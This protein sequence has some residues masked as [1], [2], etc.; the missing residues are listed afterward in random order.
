[1]N[2]PAKRVMPKG[3]R[4]G[5]ATFPRMALKD[6][7]DYAKKLVSKSH[8]APITRDV[9]YSGVLG[10]K[11]GKGN[12]KASAVKQYGLMV[13][14]QKS[15]FSASELAKKIYTALPEELPL[16]LH[17]AALSPSIFKAIFDTFH[18][19]AVPRGKLRQ[20]AADLNV[21]P[22]QAE[23]CADIYL[24][25]MVFAG[26]VTMDGDRTV[27]VASSSL[28]IKSSA[29]EQSEEVDDEHAEGVEGSGAESLGDDAVD[30]E[31]EDVPDTEDE[32][33][34]KVA[35]R[36]PVLPKAVININVSLDSTTDSDKLA[37]QLALL[38]KYGAL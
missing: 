28:A 13:G 18:S 7:V 10:A 3:G 38:R 30:D 1:M 35:P 21:H 8:T 26:L 34:G 12:V 32:R 37:K 22:D 9:L 31:G 23:D 5:G 29:E 24:K 4:K 15:G 25:T 33:T 27:H 17:H 11:S 19:D 36:R 20:R 6:A 16:L 14:N 2:K